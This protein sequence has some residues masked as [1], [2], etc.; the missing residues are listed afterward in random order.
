MLVLDDACVG[1]FP[2][3]VVHHRI[4]LVIRRVQR[5]RLKPHRAVFQFAES[6]SVILIDGTGKYNLVCQCFQFLPVGEEIA[7]QPG[8][9]SFQQPFYQYVVSAP[10]G[11]P[12]YLSLK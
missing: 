4:A 5:F 10:M 9:S 7:V 8:V 1:H 11:M 2:F 3:G 6:I 12:W